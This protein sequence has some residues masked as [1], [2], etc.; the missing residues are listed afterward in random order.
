MNKSLFENF[1]D[2]GIGDDFMNNKPYKCQNDNGKKRLELHLLSSILL[3]SF[4][5]RWIL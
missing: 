1:W 5:W 4:N 3:I 2:K